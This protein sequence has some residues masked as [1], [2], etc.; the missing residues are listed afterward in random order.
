LRA[1]VS[2]REEEATPDFLLPSFLL[3]E[4]EDV[5]RWERERFISFAYSYVFLLRIITCYFISVARN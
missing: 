4:A 5:E 1:E 2:A 3:E